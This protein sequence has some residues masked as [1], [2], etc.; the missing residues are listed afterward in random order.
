MSKFGHI[1]LQIGGIAVQVAVAASGAIPAPYSFI[2]AGGVA[3]VQA[4]A[5]IVHHGKGKS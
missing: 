3:A 2:V 1:L 4:V 5:A